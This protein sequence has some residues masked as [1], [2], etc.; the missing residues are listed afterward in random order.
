MKNRIVT[1][2]L[3][4]CVFFCDASVMRAQA[5]ARASTPQAPILPMDVKFRYVPQYI[6]QSF[7]GDPR[8]ARIE[9]LVADG[10]CD[11]VLLDKTMNRDLSTQPRIERWMP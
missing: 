9:A 4:M 11:V 1:V 2:A 3:L 10:R 7:E 6:E 5:P 8:Y